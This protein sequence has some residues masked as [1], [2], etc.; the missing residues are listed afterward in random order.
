MN[1]FNVST[2]FQSVLSSSRRCLHEPLVTTYRHLT[3][4]SYRT[5]FPTSIGCKHS[6]YH[7]KK[8]IVDQWVEVISA[9]FNSQDL[10][11]TL[12]RD[13][14]DDGDKAEGPDD[15]TARAADGDDIRRE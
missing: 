12:S 11:N 10:S 6:A 2:V 9:E 5:C 15:G 8:R 7:I 14:C 13:V 3:S 4:V 1:D